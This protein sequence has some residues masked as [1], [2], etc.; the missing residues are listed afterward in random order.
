M[1]DPP[2]RPAGA[3]CVLSLRHRAAFYRSLSQLLS[4]GA[5]VAPALEFGLGH[6]PARQRSAGGAILRASLGRGE[7]LSRGLR[8]SGMFPP[9]HVELL[10]LAEKSGH[11]DRLLG[12][13]AD[14]TDEIIEMRRDTLGGLALPAA[15]FLAAAFIA[16]VPALVLG[17]SLA[18]YL[19]S[20]LGTVAAFAALVGALALLFRRAPGNLLDRVL[21]PVPYLGTTWREFELWQLNRTLALLAH[22]S[23]GVIDAVRFSASGCRSSRLALALR[24]SAD[25][26]DRRGVPLSPLL[27]A[28][29]EFPLE[30]LAL[31]HTGEQ[32]GRL[33]ETF[34][35]LARHY[36]ASFR[37]RLRT[38]VSWT[39]RL[40]YAAVAVYLVWKI[41]QLAGGYLD[42]LNSL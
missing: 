6:L 9:A 23:I 29:G 3:S 42:T 1:L 14:F 24:L 17:G 10:A 12:E 5:P 34:Q 30:M 13:L 8:D 4:A 19:I 39:P 36:G 18:R 31:W 32:S 25:E 33:G 20:S 11:G 35:N 28:S 21:R 41:L 27:R 22:T 37:H 38:L 7:A 2:E 40:A 16:P 26:A 15:Y